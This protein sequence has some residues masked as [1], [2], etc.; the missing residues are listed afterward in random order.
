[1]ALTIN[2]NLMAYNATRN[3][4]NSYNML[5][6]SVRKLSSGLRVGTAADDPVRVAPGLD[7]LQD[8]VTALR[9]HRAPAVRRDRVP[10]DRARA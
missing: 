9:A 4:G 10:R 5:S 2:N 1:M 7:L 6:D 3:L 8:E